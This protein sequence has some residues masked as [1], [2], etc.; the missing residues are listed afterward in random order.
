MELQIN[1]I[2]NTRTS[3]MFKTGKH[4]KALMKTKR[5]LEFDINLDK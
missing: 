1:N 2:F 4:I 3:N 5:E